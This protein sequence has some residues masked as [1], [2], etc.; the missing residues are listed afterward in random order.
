MDSTFDHTLFGGNLG[1]KVPDNNKDHIK[2]SDKRKSLKENSLYTCKTNVLKYFGE[3]NPQAMEG[4][5]SI[6]VNAAEVDSLISYIESFNVDAT[7]K[8]RTND[9]LLSFLKRKTNELNWEIEK[10]PKKSIIIHSPFNPHNEISFSAISHLKNEIVLFE[11]HLQS[12]NAFELL[13]K[14]SH[15]KNPVT[16]LTKRLWGCLFFSLARYSAVLNLNQFVE[17]SRGGINIQRCDDF[18][19][20]NLFSV[21]TSSKPLTRIFPDEISIL[22][23]KHIQQSNHHI[24]EFKTENERTRWILDSIN[25][26]RSF[27]L[28][29]RELKSVSA[30]LSA[31][32]G[33][34]GLTIPPILLNIATGDQSYTSFF[35][36]VWLRLIT[37]KR[38]KNQKEAANESDAEI[39]IDVASYSK[40]AKVSP[41]NTD[42]DYKKLLNILR[43]GSVKSKNTRGYSTR[44]NV[45]E[46]LANYRNNLQEAPIVL[47][48]VIEWLCELNKNKICTVG[49]AYNYLSNVGGLLLTKLSEVEILTMESHEIAESYNEIVR[50]GSV[51][52]A[53][54]RARFIQLRRL[55]THLVANGVAP[56]DFQMSTELI[57]KPNANARII[58]EH[59][60]DQI[61]KKLYHGTKTLFEK[62]FAIAFMF[63]YRLGMRIS[64][65]QHIRLRD[66]H[67][68]E[69]ILIDKQ[70]I[71]ATL[72]IRDQKINSLKTPDA[73]RD[74]PLDIL[75]TAKELKLVF[76]YINEFNA[77][78]GNDKTQY[79]FPDKSTSKKPISVYDL[80]QKIVPLMRS[81]SGDLSIV[82]HSL[83]HSFANQFFSLISHLD[84]PVTPLPPHWSNDHLTLSLNKSLAHVLF[85]HGKISRVHAYQLA[86]WMGHTTPEITISSYVHW[87]HLLIR[88]TLDSKRVMH[89]KQKDAIEN[90]SM[91]NVGMKKICINLL[92]IDDNSYRQMLSQ[93]QNIIL[94]VV[95][96]L[97]IKP[98]NIVEQKIDAI[99]HVDNKDLRQ[100]KDPFDIKFDTWINF[101]NVLERTLD[102][103]VT[104][105][106]FNLSHEFGEKFIN[107]M[108][109]LS[110]R[111]GRGQFK[112]LPK[113]LHEVK[114]RKIKSYKSSDSA[115]RFYKTFSFLNLEPVRGEDILI[116]RSYFSVI[117]KVYKSNKLLVDKGLEY[118]IEN[119]RINGRFVLIDNTDNSKVYSK[120]VKQLA[121]DSN[122]IVTEDFKKYIGRKPFLGKLKVNDKLKYPKIK[123]T[124][125]GMMKSPEK[126]GIASH[127]FR[128]SLMLFWL[129]S[130]SMN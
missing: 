110:S 23:F 45:L 72:K 11:E 81:V 44:E 60:Y 62:S 49:S 5:L 52:Q 57:A 119:F 29:K 88:K 101:F 77:Y 94:S 83:R 123:T 98:V 107:N 84:S 41:R 82:F 86:E 15:S 68:P 114:K 124:L 92:E 129:I 46:D 87:G 65:V 25:T 10:L 28:Q 116:A 69:N 22:I 53:T 19:W 95:K 89:A 99:H 74:L 61:F 48:A 13:E 108:E 47:I 31:M 78:F 115:I 66:I 102:V 39:D 103:K 43:P 118:F 104:T 96:R 76:N 59:E 63:G 122:N 8:K 4:N 125:N 93:R 90:L 3:I 1:L 26:Y 121:N 42:S 111:G 130:K 21:E 35:D 6:K 113:I 33:F 67:F 91:N 9:Y 117:K 54:K 97:K 20:I 71:T 17:L 73:T 70:K 58:T 75:L 64:E 18:V 27:L 106:L 7:T 30:W 85:K 34:H 24:L 120:F 2:R 50:L 126:E 16:V 109:T 55:H 32:K 51:T 12:K 112:L 37:N 38:I 80:S 100:F 36:H 56:V 105:N 128:Y 127:G 79:I 40:I 14:I